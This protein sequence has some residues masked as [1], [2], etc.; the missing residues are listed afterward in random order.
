MRSAGKKWKLPGN[1]LALICFTRKKKIPT[2]CLLKLSIFYLFVYRSCLQSWLE[3]DT[4]C[5]TC[6]LALSIQ[7]PGSMDPRLDP[8]LSPDLQNDGQ[9]TTRRQP[10]HF[11]H[12]DG[13]FHIFIAKTIPFATAN[14][15]HNYGPIST[16]SSSS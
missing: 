5:P 6:R 14:C 2:N 10:N 9:A 8:L 16:M 3:Q 13:N 11:F 7:S 15:S 1:Y 12:F 4:S